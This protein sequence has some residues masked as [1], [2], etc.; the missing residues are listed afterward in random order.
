MKDGKIIDAGPA[1]E[2]VT[3]DRLLL[4]YG[5]NLCLSSELPHDEVSF[6]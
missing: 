5:E 3:K 6:R 4:V 1:K 2:I